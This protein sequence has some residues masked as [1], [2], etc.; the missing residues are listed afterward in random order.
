MDR[1]DVCASSDPAGGAWAAVGF[2]RRD[3]APKLIVVDEAWK[4]MRQPAGAE[5]I[6][7]LARSGECVL[8]E[9]RAS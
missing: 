5:F 6:D 3:L 9:W 7:E 4:V 8:H 1:G 2:L